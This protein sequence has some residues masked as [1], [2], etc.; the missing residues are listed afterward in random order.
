RSRKAISLHS[1][2]T[3]PEEILMAEDCAVH[4]LIADVALFAGDRVLLVKYRDVRRYDGQRGWFL[5]DD[6]LRFAEHPEDAAKRI[7]RE[8]AGFEVARVRLARIEAFGDGAWDVTFHD[9]A[10]ARRAR[11]VEVVRIVGEAVW[12]RLTALADDAAGIRARARNQIPYPTNVGKMPR[13]A[14]AAHASSP[15]D[16]I[17]RTNVGPNATTSGSRRNVASS[18]VHATKVKGG[19]RP[20]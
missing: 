10:E 1:P 8:Q 13:K 3:R 4:K 12:F 17:S 11:V 6:Y 16:V 19:N 2:I 15:I 9:R 18:S 5:P 14:T 20:R 7:V